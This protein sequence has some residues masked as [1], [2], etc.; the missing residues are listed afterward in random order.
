MS[1]DDITLDPGGPRQRILDAA[2]DLFSAQGYA[3]TGVREIARTAGVNQAM[4]NYYYGS[5]VNVLKAIFERSIGLYGQTVLGSLAGDGEPLE[6]RMR[7]FFGETIAMMRR[8]H[9]LFRITWSELHYDTPEIA[10]F[11]AG[12]IRERLLPALLA[13]V[14]RHRHLL[15]AGL[16]PE[17]VMPMLPGMVAWHFIVAPVYTRVIGVELDDAFYET[18]ADQLTRLTLHGLL[19]RSAADQG[20]ER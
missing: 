15:P 12:L 16:R 2:I 20:E 11:K 5:K 17:Q 9:K 14:E 1:D 10:E 4:I 19:A 18:F 8:H 13:F 3:A 6:A 7:R